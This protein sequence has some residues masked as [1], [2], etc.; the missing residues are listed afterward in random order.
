MFLG[1]VSLSDSFLNEYSSILDEAEGA[2]LSRIISSSTLDPSNDEECAAYCHIENSGC[3]MYY[4]D[5]DQSTCY[6]GNLMQT[7]GSWDLL[8][9][10][11]VKFNQGIYSKVL[12]K[13]TVLN[14]CT[15]GKILKNH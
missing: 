2:H 6:S 3:M 11:I 9:T 13:R 15:G 8:G 7:T 14:K 5:T 4:F 10:R 12:N 1:S